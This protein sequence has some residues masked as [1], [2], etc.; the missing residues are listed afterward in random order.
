MV[1][2]Q[3][4][5]LPYIFFEDSQQSTYTAEGVFVLSACKLFPLY[6]IIFL[7]APPH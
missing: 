6:V 5:L 7:Y 1:K 3:V 4:G 2:D